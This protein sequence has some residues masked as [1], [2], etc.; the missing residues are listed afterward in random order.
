MCPATRPCRRVVW[1]RVCMLLWISWFVVCCVGG[2][3]SSMNVAR[4][5]TSSP[6]GLCLHRWGYW[7]ATLARPWPRLPLSAYAVVCIAGFLCLCSSRGL[8]PHSLS[9]LSTSFITFPFGQPT[10]MNFPPIRQTRAARRA[11]TC[12]SCGTVQHFFPGAQIHV[13]C[14]ALL[15]KFAPKLR[16][17]RGNRCPIMNFN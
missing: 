16:N 8:S 2:P 14:Q 5:E 3:L 12:A 6:H 10:T 15:Q 13:A 9:V 7:A 17:R 11:R 1:W 4:A